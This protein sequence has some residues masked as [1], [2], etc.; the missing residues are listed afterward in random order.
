MNST[1]VEPTDETWINEEWI[2]PYLF[3]LLILGTIGNGFGLLLFRNSSM[4]KYSCSLYFFLMAIFDEL[5]LFW[6]VTNRLSGELNDIQ[7]RNRSTIL[8]K[9]FV[10]IYYSSSQASIGML[11]L[12]MFDRLYTSLKIAHGHF[13]VRLLTR[14]RHFQNICLSIF[15]FILIG[16]NGLLFGSQL[17]L[18]PEDDLEYC[19]IINPY[20]NRIYS[21]IDLC[22]YA[23]VPC[24]CMLVGDILI[25]YYI[26]K[27][28]AQVIA[29]NNLNKRREKQLSIMLV[30]AS[31]VS[32]FIVSPYSFL[33][34]LINFSNILNDDYRTLFILN[35]VFGLLSTF[36]HAMHFYLFLMISSTI[37]KHF[38]SL[39][40]S[41]I[42]NCFNTR[43]VI[44][45]II[46]LPINTMTSSQPTVNIIQRS[47][48]DP[49]I[50]N[51][52]RRTLKGLPGA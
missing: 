5:T 42:V 10:V 15:F 51:V 30:I 36:T 16:L 12:A 21:I 14:R 2:V 11:V 50:Y 35:D 43:N 8:C 22:I 3:L 28:R 9:L 6:W 38:K 47:P 33:N 18:P 26:Q 20:I 41:L 40:T 39:L 31:I 48:H 29:I 1:P 52:D 34:L 45:P 27:T 13:D 32:L 24:V 44:Q 25:L 37:R 46:V 17:I 4:R 19:I 7:F 23:I 49:S